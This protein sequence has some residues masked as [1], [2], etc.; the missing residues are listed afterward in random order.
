MS[1]PVFFQCKEHGSIVTL[2]TGTQEQ[3]LSCAGDK[4][5][6]M[7]STMAEGAG[8]KHLPVVEKDGSTV[9]VKVGSVAHPMT[10]EHSIDWVYLETTNGGQFKKLSPSGQPEAV[11][12]LAPGE[13]AV[14]AYS[15]CNLHGFWKTQ[16]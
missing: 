8:E 1:C 16:I 9:T 3:V 2:L 10:E 13:E 4:F 15:Y 6:V 7:D 11:F 14:A 5:H 12:A